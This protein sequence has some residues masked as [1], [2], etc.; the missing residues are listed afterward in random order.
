MCSWVDGGLRRSSA[1][2]AIESSDSFVLRSPPNSKYNHASVIVLKQFNFSIC[3]L[4][5]HMCCS[6]YCKRVGQN[7]SLYSLIFRQS[8][9]TQEVFVKHD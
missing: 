4:Y 8:A 2:A 5:E 7:L 1:R 3:S 6:L 9:F